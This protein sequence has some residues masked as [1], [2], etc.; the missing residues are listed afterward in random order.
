MTR[1]DAMELVEKLAA[2]F[3]HPEPPE[4]TL[5]LYRDEL[6]RLDDAAAARQAI[7]ELYRDPDTRYLPTLGAIHAAYVDAL[8]RLRDWRASERGLPEGD[9]RDAPIDPAVLAEIERLLGRPF[10]PFRDMDD[11]A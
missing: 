3:P 10:K 8:H 9:P 4:A 2:A 1:Q 11:A 5:E 6:Q 7:E